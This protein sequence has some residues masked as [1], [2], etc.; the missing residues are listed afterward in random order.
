MSYQW[1]LFFPV[2]AMMWLVVATMMVWHSH[3]EREMR[4]EQVREHMDYINARI[5]FERNM[6]SDVFML[7][8]FLGS[9]YNDDP[10]FNKMRISVYDT[11]NGVLIY[12]LGSPLPFDET[13]HYREDMPHDPTRREKRY[14][15]D[16]QVQE[17]ALYFSITKSMDDR[18]VVY[19]AVP[20]DH[21]VANALLPDPEI[22]LIVL[23]IAVAVTVMA[24]FSTLYLSRTVRLLRDFA[25]KA[26]TDSK[27]IPK[28]VGFPSDEVGDVGRQIIHIFNERTKAFAQSQK[29]HE[30]AL[31]TIAEKAA[32]KRR[33][34]NN[35][36]HELKTPVCIVKGYIDTIID[37]PD[38][39]ERSRNRFMKKAQDN[40]NRMDSL[41]KD[42]STL[43]RFDEASDII[44][45]EPTDFYDVVTTVESENEETGCVG[46]MKFINGV[47]QGT[48]VEGNFS[49]LVA[50]L[51]NLTK[52]AVAYSHGS[53]LGVR[54]DREDALMYYFTFFDDG[55]GVDEEHLEHLFERFYCVDSGRSRKSCGTGLGLPIVHDTVEFHGGEISVS[56][57]EEGGL[58]FHFSLRKA[59]I[60]F[61]EEEDSEE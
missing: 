34:T 59:T 61:G 21:V 10:I 43:N 60:D 39:D 9:F 15:S 55:Q 40:I 38:M 53:Q 35:I 13:D 58:E 46:G 12:S 24:Y 49:L 29:E 33:M 17:N 37:N 51:H 41:I 2:I 22:W 42:I 23:A 32:L 16:P 28:E 11:E 5:L 57:A 8:K 27:F 4:I 45:T 26:A 44:P 52:N 50:M 47:P 6:N 30:L 7:F 20:Y 36:S 19:S 1:R 54:L 18:M 48:I 14:K 31:K 25:R 3:Q 56:N